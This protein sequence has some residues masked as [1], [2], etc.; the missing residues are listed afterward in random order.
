MLTIFLWYT[1]CYNITTVNV[2]V[3]NSIVTVT[4][5][6]LHTEKFIFQKKTPRWEYKHI[7]YF[8]NTLLLIDCEEG[9]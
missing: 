9:Q 5:L 8:F 2:G 1:N 7:T 4:V 3:N 6:L